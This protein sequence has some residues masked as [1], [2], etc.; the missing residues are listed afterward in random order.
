VSVGCCSPYSS[1]VPVRGDATPLADLVLWQDR[2]GT[3][4][5]LD[6][7]VHEGG[8]ETW[9]ERHGIPPVGDGLSLAH[10]LHFQD[11]RPEIHAAAAAYF[12]PM[13]T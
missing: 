7:L 1:I 8:F 10:I 6:L 11:D 5:S 3:D 2:R 12:E 13:A 9:V 4:H